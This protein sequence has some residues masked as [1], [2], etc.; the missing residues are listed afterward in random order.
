AVVLCPSP[1][2]TECNPY[3]PRD[4][5]AFKN[6]CELA[7]IGLAVWLAKREAYPAFENWMFTF[8]SGDRWHPKS[9]EETRA[10]AIELVGQDQLDAALSDEWIGEYLQTCTHIF[11]RTME[12]GKGGIPKIVYDSH[13]VIPEPNS[14]DELI[15][16]LQQ[17][18]GVPKR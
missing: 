1:L 13:W 3:V 11:G 15:R 12:N 7:R 4:V 18:L 9:L 16:I 17:S 14:T 8:E 2:N 5:A 6:S 10:K